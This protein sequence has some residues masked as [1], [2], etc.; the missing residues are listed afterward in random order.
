MHAMTI[1]NSCPGFRCND[2]D[3]NINSC[4][5]TI[6]FSYILYNGTKQKLPKEYY[7]AYH[8]AGHVVVYLDMGFK[9]GSVTIIPEYDEKGESRKVGHVTTP[10]S[11]VYIPGISIQ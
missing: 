4:A 2:I 8:E 7:T 6:I 1:R 3:M 9:Y 5:M 10:S 11:S